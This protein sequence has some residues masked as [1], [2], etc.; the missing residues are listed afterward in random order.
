MARTPLSH[1]YLTIHVLGSLAVLYLLW[2]L[3]SGHWQPFLL[4][5]G[6]LCAVGVLLLALR[7][8]V[9]DHESYPLH[10]RPWRVLGYWMWLVV[11]IVKAN[12]DVAR[13][14]LDPALPISPRVVRLKASQRTRLGRVIYA[15][16]ITLTP[17][18]VSIDVREDD[19]HIEVHAL[20]QEAAAAL[21]GGGM[22]RRVSRLEARGD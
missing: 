1:R 21:E 5:V 6:A 8:E 13:R 19:E 12:V 3:L 9:I 17:G 10:L 2:L 20:T 11:E 22:D 7:M 14:I 16:S 18:T 4:S 15:N